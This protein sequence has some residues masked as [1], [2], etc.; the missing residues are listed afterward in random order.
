MRKIILREIIILILSVAVLPVA[1]IL[2]LVH[3][4]SLNFGLVILSREIMS[5]GSGLI[6]GPLGLCVK[7]LSPYLLVQSIRAFFWAR[8][9][10]TGMRWANIYFAVLLACV[11]GWFLRDAWDLLY[12]MYA[13]GDL[14]GELAQFFELEVSNLIIFVGAVFLAVHCIRT[15]LNPKRNLPSPK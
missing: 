10:V 1:V 8:R 14:P 11:A 4:N 15:A 5:G 7:L 9:S 2:Y 13:L 3:T 6:G 12:M